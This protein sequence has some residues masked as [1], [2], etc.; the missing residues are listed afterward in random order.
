MDNNILFFDNE[1]DNWQKTNKKGEITKDMAIHKDQINFIEVNDTTP[2]ILANSNQAYLEYFLNNNNTY[3][4]FINTNPEKQKQYLSKPYV[5]NGITPELLTNINF[6]QWLEDH[7]GMTRAAIFFDW[8]RTI[9]CVEGMVTYGLPLALQQEQ[10]IYT[11]LLLFLMGG[12][13]R[14]DFI[15]QMFKDI[16]ENDIHFFIL[17]H[18]LYASKIK[19][20]ATRHIY[21]NL[22]KMLTGL[23]DDK[24]DVDKILFSSPDYGYKKGNSACYTMANTIITEML[25]EC[26]KIITERRETATGTAISRTTSTA[27]A[28]AYKVNNPIVSKGGMLHNSKSRSNSKRRKSYKSK[29][30]NKNKNKTRKNKK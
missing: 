25:P 7:N 14:L 29:K 10:V 16:M 8:D 4:Q 28:K 21:I 19:G 1:A 27:T 23:T 24:F 26:E 17:T 6:N 3:A 9:T 13:E 11:D 2:N 20:G 12:Q 15:K 18:N 30:Q 5:N 22:L